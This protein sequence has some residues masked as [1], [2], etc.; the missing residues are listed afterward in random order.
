MRAIDSSGAEYK[1]KVLGVRV[2]VADG[3]ELWHDG[4]EDCQRSFHHGSFERSDPNDG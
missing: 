1:F 2:T 3:F 4:W